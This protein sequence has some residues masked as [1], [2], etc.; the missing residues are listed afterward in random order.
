MTTVISNDP[1]ERELQEMKARMEANREAAYAAFAGLTGNPNP[2]A[3]EATEAALAF[4][5]KP[6]S[7]SRANGHS[8]GA[9]S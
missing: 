3:E 8:F 9:G 2:S 6:S 7:P 1:D 5:G 4:G